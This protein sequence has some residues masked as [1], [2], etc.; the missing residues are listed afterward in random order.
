MLVWSLGD[1]DLSECWFL[2]GFVL[3]VWLLRFVSICFL[4]F[5]CVSDHMQPSSFQIFT[6]QAEVTTALYRCKSLN[7]LRLASKSEPSSR[8]EDLFRNN[9]MS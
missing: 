1:Q 4:S 9:L 5:L 6:Q 7:H 8:Y 2:L 3:V